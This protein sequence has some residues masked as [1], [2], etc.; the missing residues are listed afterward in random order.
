MI[1]SKLIKQALRR[2]IR[3]QRDQYIWHY[4][5]AAFFTGFPQYKVFC[6]TLI[7]QVDI[8]IES[9]IESVSLA[10]LFTLAMTSKNR[11]AGNISVFGEF[12]IRPDKR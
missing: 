2:D 5:F 4:H 10:Y 1:P 12:N 8:N 7:S 9:K 6:F 11:T 3:S